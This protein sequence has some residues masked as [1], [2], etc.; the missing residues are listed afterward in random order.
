MGISQLPHLNPLSRNEKLFCHLI[1]RQPGPLS[2]RP[3]TLGNGRL[4]CLNQPDNVLSAGRSPP[5]C[6]L[7][8]HT[9]RV[10]KNFWAWV[11]HL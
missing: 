4:L 6:A 11:N 8:S 9:R 10:A 2:S 7:G 1:K 3:Q 5:V